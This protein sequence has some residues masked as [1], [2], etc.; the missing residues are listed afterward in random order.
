MSV[1]CELRQRTCVAEGLR[2]EARHREELVLAPCGA[3]VGGP[4]VPHGALHRPPPPAGAR[5]ISPRSALSARAPSEAPVHVC[6][7]SCQRNALSSCLAGCCGHSGKQP[8]NSGTPEHVM[9]VE[10]AGDTFRCAGVL[11]APACRSHQRV[12]L[13]PAGPSAH[14]SQTRLPRASW[15][16]CLP[17]ARL[18]VLRCALLCLSQQRPLPR[19]LSSGPVGMHE[20]YEGCSMVLRRGTR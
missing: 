5:T 19:S 2:A 1:E 13:T 20:P 14:P 3:H 6:S 10:G 17:T 11:K 4:A 16:P 8:D 15:H 9:P 7:M 18:L 12:R